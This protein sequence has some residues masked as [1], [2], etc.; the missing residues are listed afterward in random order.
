MRTI[1]LLALCALL[2]ACGGGAVPTDAGRRR[3]ARVPPGQDGG[4]EEDG[5]PPELFDAGPTRGDGGV[6]GAAPIAPIAADRVTTWNPGILADEQLHLPLG[7]DELP[8]RTEICSTLSPGD[9]IQ[10]AIDSCPEGQ[11]VLLSP[12]TFTVSDTITLTR[13]VVLRGSGSQGAPSGTTIRKSGGETV[14]AIGESRDSICYG[15]TGYALTEDAAKESTVVHVGSAASNFAAGQLAIIDE[16]DDPTVDQGDCPYFKREDGRSVSQRV[17]IVAVDRAA[18]T[19]T[20]GSPLHWRFRAGSPRQAEIAPVDEPTVRWAGIEHLRLRDGNNPGYNG[21]MAGGIDISNAAYSWVSDVQTDE[22]IGGMHVSVTA[23][24]RV[25]VRDSYFHHSADYGFGHDCYGIV[26]RCGAA[27]GLVENNIVRYMNKPIMLNVSGGGNVI[28]YNYAD[29]SWATPA[30]WQEVNIDCHC[31]FPHMELIEGN[32]A[33]HVGATVTHGNNGYL[34]F[35][36]NYSSSRF[37]PPAVAGSNEEQTGNITAIQFPTGD[38]GMNVLGNVLGSEGYSRVYDAYDS[39][40]ISIYSLGGAGDVS[41]TSLYR[42]GNYDYVNRETVWDPSDSAHSLP[43]SLYRSCPPGWWP[44][45][46]PW[47]WAGPDL[48]PMVGTLPAKDRSDHL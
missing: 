40:P 26:L 5:G 9:D 36:R 41:A 12:G 37:A 46:L 3:D 39:D 20:L 34:T 25:V 33:P 31:S 6:C 32:Y 24:Y 28:A 48:D 2:A 27:E 47:P 30:A 19:L 10:D 43:P 42:S 1:S 18:G 38:I 45:S 44:A 35:Y 11:V 29:N 22:T 7:P 23:T 15:A 13:G 8:V 17:E 16:T 14:L 4:P 21:Q